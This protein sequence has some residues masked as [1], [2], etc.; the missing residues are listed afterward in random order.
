[1]SPRRVFIYLALFCALGAYFYL[2]EVLGTK[3]K[4]EEA[5]EAKRLFKVEGPDVSRVLIKRHASEIEVKKHGS[6]WAVTRPLA[7][8]AD[9][10]EVD[11]LVEGLT[12]ILVEKEV[13]E[14]G[15]LARFGLGEPSLTVEF[16]SKSGQMSLLVGSSAPVGNGRYVMRGREKKVLLV[17]GSSLKPLEKSLYQLR[18]KSLFTLKPDE[19][20]RLSIERGKVSLDLVKGKGGWSAPEIEGLRVSEQKV[21]DVLTHLQYV[22]AA[23]F[24]DDKTPGDSGLTDPDIVVALDGKGKRETLSLAPRDKEGKRAAITSI[25]QGVILVHDSDLEE[26]P[27]SARD[28][29]DRTFLAFDGDKVF[30][31]RFLLERGK[32]LRFQKG[33]S[34]WKS[35]SGKSLES[36]V[37]T[38][39]FNRL[40]GLEYKE[41][42]GGP[43]KDDPV[44]KVTLLGKENR[45]LLGVAFYKRQDGYL[46]AAGQRAYSLEGEGG[47]L[48]VDWVTSVLKRAGG[49][50]E[51]SP[52]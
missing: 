7:A 41:R 50:G 36:W 24:L 17:K 27:K 46:A 52:G 19:V 51:K 38:A 35:P 1:M 31:V 47:R 13:A 22:R 40:K 10:F 34:G 28:V 18:D 3:K 4:A 20:E 5:R 39:M 8:P 30:G 43:P 23:K 49:P 45:E 16:T 6:R 12:S 26:L 33:K 15:E 32:E 21:S 25:R 29:E 11:T 48:L 42:L 14:G 37:L 2:F 44:F 9:S